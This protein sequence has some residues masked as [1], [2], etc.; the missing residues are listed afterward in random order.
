M[1]IYKPYIYIWDRLL[2]INSTWHGM[3][4][5][6]IVKYTISYQYIQL[7]NKPKKAYYVMVQ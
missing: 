7:V 4:L 6:N 5:Y 3:S 2:C 1:Y